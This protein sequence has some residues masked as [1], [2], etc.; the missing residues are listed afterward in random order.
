VTSALHTLTGRELP[1]LECADPDAG[2]ADMWEWDVECA[3]FA[4]PEVDVA[5]VTCRWLTDGHP[6]TRPVDVP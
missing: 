2:E 5:G 4:V 3:W 1:T 6:P